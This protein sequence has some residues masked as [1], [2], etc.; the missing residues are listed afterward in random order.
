VPTRENSFDDPLRDPSSISE[1]VVIRDT[2]IARLCYHNVL[3][4]S[5]R[6]GSVEG[7]LPATGPTPAALVG[8]AAL[9]AGQGDAAQCRRMPGEAGFVTVGWSPRRSVSPCA[10]F[11]D[12]DRQGPEGGHGRP[13]ASPAAKVRSGSIAGFRGATF[14]TSRRLSKPLNFRPQIAN[15]KRPLIS[16]GSPTK[17]SD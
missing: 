7:R 14:E 13:P 8:G 2:L 16:P 4:S 11:Y 1:L 12:L 17:V 9:V 6:P 3:W 10:R 15:T 5:R